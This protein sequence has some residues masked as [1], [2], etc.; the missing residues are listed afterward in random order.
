MCLLHALL[1][2]FFKSRV[3]KMNI[4]WHHRDLF[5][6]PVQRRYCNCIL[7]DICA[8]WHPQSVVNKQ[9][10]L[11]VNTIAASPE[12][13]LANEAQIKEKIAVLCCS[14]RRRSSKRND[15]SGN[16]K[17]KVIKEKLFA[18]NISTIYATLNE[19][20]VWTYE[21]TNVYMY[22]RQN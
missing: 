6:P 4:S 20:Y 14:W 1:S 16:A 10:I 18:N 15:T 2:L 3:S 13:L 12:K 7:A 17:N 19:A 9:I 22:L 8:N 5:P 11:K 21:Y